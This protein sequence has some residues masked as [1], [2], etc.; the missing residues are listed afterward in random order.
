M[1]IVDDLTG[2]VGRTAARTVKRVVSGVETAASTVGG[3]AGIITS[4]V[5]GSYF[6]ALE[7][8]GPA[9][10]DVNKAAGVPLP[11]GVGGRPE[12]YTFDPQLLIHADPASMSTPG[13]LN[14]LSYDLLRLVARWHISAAA[15]QIRSNEAARFCR[16]EP[17]PEMAGCRVQLR[18]S[19][20]SPSPAAKKK[21]E[22]MQRFFQN[23]GVWDANEMWQ[24][25]GFTT[26]V[27]QFV[28]DSMTFDQSC[29]EIIPDRL[30]RPAAFR[31]LPSHTIRRA[32]PTKWHLDEHGDQRPDREATNFVQVYQ[33]RRIAEW[34]GEYLMWGIRRQR[35]DL[36]SYGYGWP[37]FEETMSLITGISWSMEYNFAKF[38]QGLQAAGMLTVSGQMSEGMF[39]SWVED[40]KASMTGVANAHRMSY[41][42]LDDPNAK[43]NFEDF[44]KSNKDEEFHQW[45]GTLVKLYCAVILMDP[46]QLNLIFGAEGVTG[47]LTQQG[48]EARI[49]LS[50]DR[51]LYPLLVFISE[52][53]NRYITWQ[54]DEDFEFKFNLN[55]EDE[56]ARLE[57]RIKRINTYMTVNEA[58]EEED[59]PPREDGDVIL[60]Q[61]WLQAKHAAEQPPDMPG[62]PGEGEEGEPLPEGEDDFPGLVGPDEA[63]PEE[64]GDD[65]PGL[66]PPDEAEKGAPIPSWQPGAPRPIS[67]VG[68]PLTVYEVRH[69]KPE[70]D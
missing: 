36:E 47:A 46:A 31:A 68:R 57:S 69:G 4:R 51:G 18:E 37:E 43:T 7:K 62:M 66:E 70:D 65:F 14:R 16:F 41:L 28:R 42:L 5:M 30:G 13:P 10:P 33:Q 29:T 49:L 56:A 21:I 34:P 45:F 27:K 11:P 54:I 60:N 1:G 12:P 19:K 2:R 3:G 58:R 23:C 17:H 55:P 39:K 61:V 35:T 38:K 44:K 24:H 48:P 26:W 32:I 64:E 53:L 67:V 40:F 59:M 20:K 50:Q 52:N 63:F 8:G 6:D 15:I 25:A 9:K 22:E